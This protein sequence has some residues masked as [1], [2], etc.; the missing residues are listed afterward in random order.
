ME[1][2]VDVDMDVEYANIWIIWHSFSMHLKAEI[3]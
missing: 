3:C 1:G 2:M